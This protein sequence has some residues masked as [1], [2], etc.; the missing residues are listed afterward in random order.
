MGLDSKSIVSLS[1]QNAMR[2]MGRGVFDVA[3]RSPR[4]TTLQSVRA[5]REGGGMSALA[6]GSKISYSFRALAP[7]GVWRSNQSS[8]RRTSP[9]RRFF[10]PGRIIFNGGSCGEVERPAGVLTG[11]YC[12]PRTIRH[13]LRSK[14]SG[15]LQT[16][17]GVS[18]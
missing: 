6:V 3:G 8:V 15:G 5:D 11:R 14:S 9:D 7:V 10:M 12:Y 1:R 16:Q 4:C 13:H 2:E 18:L 17:L